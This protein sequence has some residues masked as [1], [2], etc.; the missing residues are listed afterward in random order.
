MD[1]Y[2]TYCDHF[3]IYTST[4][5]LCCKTETSKMLYVISNIPIKEKQFNNSFLIPCLSVQHLD[6]D[7]EEHT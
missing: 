5:S 7:S 2:C 1:V 4:E 3:I 6:H